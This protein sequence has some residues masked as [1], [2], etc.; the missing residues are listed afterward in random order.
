MMQLKKRFNLQFRTL[1]ISFHLKYVSGL[2][3]IG[4]ITMENEI[5]RNIYDMR[6]I[7]RRKTTT[8]KTN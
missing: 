3:L 2:I 4:I 6:N 1:E 7:Y 5:A 8:G